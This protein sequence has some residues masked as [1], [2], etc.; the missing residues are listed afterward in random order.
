MISMINLNKKQKIKSFQKEINN[1]ISSTKNDIQKADNNI[2][3]EVA[4][5]SICLTYNHNDC[6]GKY[7]DSLSGKYFIKCLCDCH[8]KKKKEDDDSIE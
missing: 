8:V 6:N 3:L 1:S 4:R 7:I 2:S 5:V